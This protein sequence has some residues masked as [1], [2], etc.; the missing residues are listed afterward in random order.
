MEITMDKQMAGAL[1]PESEVFENLALKMSEEKLEE[2][3][4]DMYEGYSRDYNSLGVLREHREQYIKLFELITKKK[5]TPWA[6][7][8]NVLLPTITTACINFQ[9]RASPVIL[10]PYKIV[11]PI[12]NSNQETE[13]KKGQRV[14][15]YMNYQLMF[16]MKEFYSSME[17]TLLLLARDGF[18]FRKVYWDSVKG[19]P[20]S[21]YV[22]PDDFIVDAKTRSLENCYRY[23]QHLFMNPNDVKIKTDQ[24]LYRQIK[25]VDIFQ[26]STK[27]NEDMPISSDNQDQG[28]GYRLI[29]ECH[30]YCDIEDSGIKDPVV[31][32]MDK[33]SQQILRIVRRINPKTGKRIDFFVNYIFL[34][35]PGSIFG[36][37]FGSL[38]YGINHAINTAINQMTDAGT[39][40]NQKGGFIRKSAG[41]KRG[42]ML[43]SMGEFKEIEIR[44]DEKLRDQVLPLEFQPPSSV[45]MT[46]ATFLQGYADRL[47]TVTELFT[48]AAPRSDTTASSTAIAVEQGAKVFTAIQGRIHRTLGTREVYLIA[49]MNSMYLD[50]VTYY[51][52]NEPVVDGT[53]SQSFVAIEDFDNFPGVALVTDPNVISDAQLLQKADY[54]AQ[55]VQTNPFLAQNPQA[56][57]LVM[58]RRLE[59]I[60]ETP[61][62]IT[63]LSSIMDQAVLQ[64]Q[65]QSQMAAAQAQGG[66]QNVNAPAQGDEQNVNAPA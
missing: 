33:D 53:G 40:S 5:D 8:S 24:K 1:N 44:G 9:S 57:K 51:Q 31:I 50:E 47:T 12:I 63:Q 61:Y 4:K 26:P 65:Q 25:D 64:M 35:N 17:D 6:G 58:E 22:L 38:L 62:V 27:S 28:I 10:P 55:I 59:A 56:L 20:V 49:Q 18:A 52:V 60:G 14:A 16:E 41:F 11:K 36:F 3:S 48:G 37:G 7:A 13:Y 46:L 32:T 42:R 29:L 45:L 54:M 23:T 30:T 19:R 15:K 66:E 39:L 34:N 43:F 21:D 2:I